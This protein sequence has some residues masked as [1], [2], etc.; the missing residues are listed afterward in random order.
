[1]SS[2]KE[3]IEKYYNLYD[4][5]QLFKNGQMYVVYETDEGYTKTVFIYHGNIKSFIC[6]GMSTL[7][8]DITDE[9]NP[10]REFFRGVDRYD[11][12]IRDKMDAIYLILNDG[13]EWKDYKRRDDV[14][15]HITRSSWVPVTFEREISDM[16]MFAIIAKNVLSS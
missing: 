13:K 1:M 8:E 14:F 5:Y 15:Y 12:E 16:D 3:D 6:S 9:T 4:S 2:L 7:F 11:M 10:V